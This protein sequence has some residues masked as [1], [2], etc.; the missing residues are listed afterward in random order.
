MYRRKYLAVFAASVLLRENSSM[1]FC[2]N[3]LCAL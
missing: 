2:G 3:Y 1:F